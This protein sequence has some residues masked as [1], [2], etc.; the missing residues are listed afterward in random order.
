LIDWLAQ[1]H[2]VSREDLMPSLYVHEE[3]A[4]IKHLMRVSCGLDSLVLGEPQI[5]GQVKQAFS[6]SRDHQAVDLSIDKL[7]QKT[8]SVA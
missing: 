2:Q 6:D 8:F 4:A 1:F 3:Q 7:F 5:L